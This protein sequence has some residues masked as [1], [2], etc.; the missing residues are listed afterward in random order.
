MAILCTYKD[1]LVEGITPD[2]LESGEAAILRARPNALK[3]V[4]AW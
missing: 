1:P 2:C 3:M 4:S